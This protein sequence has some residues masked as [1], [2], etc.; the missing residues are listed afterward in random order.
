ME[1]TTTLA[2]T[3]LEDL[4]DLSD[5]GGDDDDYNNRNDDFESHNR[6]ML[7][8]QQQNDD[9]DEV[10][11][12]ITSP[13]QTQSTK[14]NDILHPRLLNDN[15]IQK[16]LDAIRKVM[17]TS[18]SSSS[19]N[20]S[21]QGGNETLLNNNT[22]HV[23][24][25]E[26]RDIEYQLIV[27]SNKHLLNLSNELIRVHRLLCLSYK[28][29]FAEL[30]ELVPNPI[31]YTKAIRIIGNEMDMT[32]ITDQLTLFLT[33]NQIIT[34]SV[35]GSTTNGRPLYEWEI[36]QV[37]ILCS[38][39]EDIV[40][41]QN[42]ILIY[43]QSKMEQLLPNI[44]ILLNSTSITAKL[45]G[46]AGGFEELTKIPSCNLQVLGQTKYNTMNRNGLSS[47][48]SLL[49][50]HQGILNECDL[51]QNVSKNIQMKVLKMVSS[52][53]ALAI[54][55]DYINLETGRT[56]TAESG[57]RFRDEIEQKINKLQEPDK[58]QVLK[59]LPK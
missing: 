50:V 5:I 47:S 10:M 44:C 39:I 11:G 42:E 17:L 3:L 38:Y 51:V 43:V 18:S 24:G 35:A 48:S 14:Q 59:A 19:S 22:N 25:K 45:L 55:C 2:N 53:L 1:A 21:S 8:D 41:I 52:K 27:K 34:I 57:R 40:N 37:N 15:N 54:R 33:N 6:Q 9:D 28:M 16:H 12:V 13:Q 49:K 31:Q 4:D 23:D 36:N 56:R 7:V 30:E 29:K 58:A 46:L 20:S 32:R 26:D